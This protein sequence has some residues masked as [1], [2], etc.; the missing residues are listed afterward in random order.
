MGQR[1]VYGLDNQSNYT[2][3]EMEHV[4][5]EDMNEEQNAWISHE[6]HQELAEL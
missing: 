2:C 5:H 1:H 6:L 3:A 4:E